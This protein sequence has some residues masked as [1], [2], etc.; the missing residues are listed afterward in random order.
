[1]DV[2]IFS[3]GKVIIT[4]N[5][6]VDDLIA[7]YYNKIREKLSYTKFNPQELDKAI[8]EKFGNQIKREYNLKLSKIKIE[9][10]CF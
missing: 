10:K 9:K 3:S 6:Q 2:K 8:Q 4:K 1:M 7:N 5:N